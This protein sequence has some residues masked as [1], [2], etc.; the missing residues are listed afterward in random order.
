MAT[1]SKG[2]VVRTGALTIRA[3]LL[4]LALAAMVPIL[5]FA[6]AV[7]FVLV[8]QNRD[9][10]RNATMDRA[11]AMLTA[12]DAELRGSIKTLE[13]LATTK[14][15]ETGDLEAFHAVAVRVVASQPTWATITLASSDL[16]L[17]MSAAQPVG[18]IM[19]GLI[20]SASAAP[21]LRTRLPVIGDVI[22]RPEL[23]RGAAIPIRVPVMQGGSLAYILTAAV[24]PESFE[25][26]IRQ[27]N[28]PAG[29]VIG[30]VDGNG[31]FVARVPGRVAGTPAG[32]GFRAAMKASPVG[33]YRGETVE[34]LDTYTAHLRS[35]FS[36]WTIGL[37]L[38]AEFVQA[39]AWRTMWILGLGAL[40]SILIALVV[41]MFMGRRIARPVA[42]LA[43]T[44][45]ALGSER[46]PRRERLDQ[47]RE[48]AEVAAALEQSGSA[49]RER[50]QL[51]EREK[52]ALMEADRAKDQFIAMLSHELRNPLAALTSAAHLLKVAGP[53]SASDHA[54][55][56]I[57]RQTRHM[58]R[59]IEDLL[60]INRV[61]MGKATLIREPL[62]LGELVE[63]VVRT[64][65]ESGRLKEHT[66]EVS[67]SRVPID[68]DRSRIEQVFS[69]LLENALK[70]TPPGKKVTVTVHREGA[71]AVLLIADEGE[72]IDSDLVDRIF[73]LF[74][75]G[76]QALDRQ[77]GG[78]GVGLALVKGLVELH[79]GS[80]RAS[81]QGRGKGAAFIVRLPATGSGVLPVPLAHGPT[82]SQATARQIIIVEDNDDGRQMLR[83]LLEMSG[84]KV[85][86]AADAATGLRMAAE[87]PPDVMLIDIGLPDMNGY[88]LATRIRSSPWGAPILMIALTGYGQAEDKRLALE[89]GFDAHATK[90]V[91][92][93]QLAQMIE[94]AGR[95]SEDKAA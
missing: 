76:P 90:P 19:P 68:A 43:A 74:V 21:V 93:Q 16:K 32:A 34:G 9:E 3:H 11:R 45:R 94:A 10:M 63:D 89:A 8:Q 67:T 73:D 44:A 53:G 84:N 87:H 37:A 14:A 81:S 23:L 56:V 77:S 55:G 47:V 71:D 29:W 41:A 1:H 25:T 5:A 92:P 36:N 85:R 70:F 35:E 61:A 27:Q 62:D 79:G 78:L 60:D 69:N 95:A 82:A 4:L 66:V 30:I 22:N 51:I 24:R 46:A 64:W 57:E 20:D 26:L 72:G 58:T 83:V 54:R 91:L 17:V 86:E 38:P 39:G 75:Q 2:P 80:V 52:G 7:S 33:W 50:Q 13:G 15:L 42:G 59:L 28:L 6:V 18:Q 88:E 65:R 48:V 31:N 12:V 40:A 49:I